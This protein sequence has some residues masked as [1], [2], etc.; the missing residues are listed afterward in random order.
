MGRIGMKHASWFL[1]ACAVPAAVQAVELDTLPEQRADLDQPKPGERRPAQFLLGS[2]GVVTINTGKYIGSDERVTVPLPLIYFNYNDRLFWSIASVGTWIW[3]TDDRR[4]KIGLLV[5][6][7]GGL[8]GDQTE[9]TGIEDRDPSIDAGLNLAWRLSP[10]VIGASWFADALDRSH[11]QSANVRFSLPVALGERWS[12]VP[13]IAVDWQN[14]N[15]VDYY[16]GVSTSETS[17]G[18]PVY[19]GKATTNLIAGWSLRYRL[20]RQWSI[21]GGLSYSHLG[22]GIA[23]SPLVS[24]SSNLLVYAAASWGFFH[25]N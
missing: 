25:W 12:M 8:K 7:R 19:A 1:L 5:K 23:D 18:A 15:L 11:G 22:D 20:S 14:R 13:G 3:R 9:Y 10:V 24:Q 21:T 17:G 6:A 16:F 4:F 2:L